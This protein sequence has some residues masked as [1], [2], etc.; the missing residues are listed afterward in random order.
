MNNI[1]YASYLCNLLDPEYWANRRYYDEPYNTVTCDVCDHPT[2]VYATERIDG[3]YVCLDCYERWLNP[4]NKKQF[5]GDPDVLSAFVE[6][7]YEVCMVDEFIENSGF[8]YGWWLST[9]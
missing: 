2:S 3:N 4:H 5:V 1:G 6:Y 9:H 8:D 7:M